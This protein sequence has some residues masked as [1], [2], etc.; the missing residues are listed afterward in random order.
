MIFFYENTTIQFSN[1]KMPTRKNWQSYSLSKRKI[2]KIRSD[3]INQTK[4]ICIAI[5]THI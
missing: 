1:S 3:C 4:F 5:F 2:I